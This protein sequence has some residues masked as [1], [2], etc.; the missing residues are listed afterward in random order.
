MADRCMSRERATPAAG[1]SAPARHRPVKRALL[2][3]YIIQLNVWHDLI[4]Q[5]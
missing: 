5:E 4:K 2:R 1:R 3:A